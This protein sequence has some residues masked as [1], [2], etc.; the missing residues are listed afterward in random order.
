M[1]WA[2]A[3][4]AGLL[5]FAVA[6]GY[7][8]AADQAARREKLGAE[9]ARLLK[10][11]AH[12]EA[13]QRSERERLEA[14]YGRFPKAAELPA[15][16]QELHRLA[17]SH[18]VALAR[19]DY[20]ASRDAGTGLQRVSLNLPISGPFQPTYDWLAEVLASMPEVALESLTLK[21]ERTEEGNLDMEVRLVL[22][23]RGA[24]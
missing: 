20:R 23:V 1:G 10:L 15:R 19:A 6:F 17:E 21:R 9:R 3:L 13:D 5:A 4:G 2:G 24:T 22:F 14:F 16:L 7:T 11:A 12:P 8:L 18:G